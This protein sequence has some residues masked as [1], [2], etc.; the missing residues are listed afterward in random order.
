MI[1]ERNEKVFHTEPNL[2]TQEGFHIIPWDMRQCFSSPCLSLHLKNSIP[3]PKEIENWQSAVRETLMEDN[4]VSLISVI[5]EIWFAISWI[6]DQ[7][8]KWL[9]VNP[10]TYLAR[11]ALR[12]DREGELSQLAAVDIFLITVDPLKEPPL[13]TA[14]TVLSILAVDYP[15]DKVSCY[16]SDDGAAMLTFEAPLETSSL[17]EMGTFLQEKIDYLKDK[18]QP[19]FLKDHRALKLQR[20]RKFLEEEWI[21]QDGTPWPDTPDLHQSVMRLGVGSSHRSRQERIL[22]STYGYSKRQ[23]RP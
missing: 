23:I 19:S 8:P 11:L 6:L 16:V 5:C 10:E 17:P 3:M 20:H 14:N 1:K 18:V 4:V 21:M 12:Y 2:M 13:V 22:A 9:P 7:Y 15:V